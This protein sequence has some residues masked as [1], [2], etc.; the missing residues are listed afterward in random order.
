MAGLKS[1]VALKGQVINRLGKIAGFGL[2]QGKGF[3]KP[4]AHP[5]PVLW[6]NP[7]NS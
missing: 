5:Y 6:G 4:A 1:G 2:K 3:G 7:L